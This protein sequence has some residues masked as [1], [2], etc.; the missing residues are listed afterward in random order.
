MPDDVVPV[1][2]PGNILDKEPTVIAA[3]VFAVVNFVIAAGTWTIDVETLLAGETALVLV[4]SLFV[5]TK[6]TS[7]STAQVLVEKAKVE[8]EVQVKT[9]VDTFLNAVAEDETARMV[10]EA[11]SRFT[12]ALKESEAE[13]RTLKA[14]LATAK[15]AP[16]KKAAGATKKR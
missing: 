5:R 14:E 7:N 2:R 10:D 6:S 13:I 11:H 16:A 4:L 8:A 3:A 15:K 12:D 9:E 1:Y